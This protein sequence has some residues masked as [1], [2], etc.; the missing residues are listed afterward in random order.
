MTS[1]LNRLRKMYGVEPVNR[2]LSILN[3]QRFQGNTYQVSRKRI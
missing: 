1:T 2:I 3:Q